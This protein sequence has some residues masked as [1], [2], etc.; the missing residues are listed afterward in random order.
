MPRKK[1]QIKQEVFNFR[2]IVL[3]YVKENPNTR[4]QDIAGHL[5]PDSSEPAQ[6]MNM[7]KLVNGYTKRIS[8][9]LIGRICKYFKCT[10][11]DLFNIK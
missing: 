7:S 4:Q 3:N 9:D 5:W 10:P 11:N 2:N 8:I 6:R 1:E